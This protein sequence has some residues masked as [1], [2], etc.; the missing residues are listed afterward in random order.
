MKINRLKLTSFGQQKNRII[1]ISDNLNMIFGTT[2][3]A[4]ETVRDFIEAMF[5]G[6]DPDKRE[7]YTPDGKNC[8]GEMLL[9]TDDGRNIRLI[10]N[11]T[12]GHTEVL[13]E[14]GD[15]ITWQY[16]DR[17]GRFM[18]FGQDDTTL[19]QPPSS[20]KT[21]I[22]DLE[23]ELNKLTNSSALAA[24]YSR[25]DSLQQ[26]LDTDNHNG[27]LINQNNEQISQL[28]D[29][30]NDVRDQVQA[31]ADA[32]RYE[33][34]TLKTNNEQIDEELNKL[35]ES[36]DLHK[37]EE[38]SS[39]SKLLERN[40]RGAAERITAITKQLNDLY[41][42]QDVYSERLEMLTS[43]FHL[44]RDE[45]IS[46]NEK[47][48]YAENQEK[49]NGTEP[50]AVAEKLAGVQSW[51]YWVLIVLGIVLDAA[52]LIN[53][54]SYLPK[55]AVF[56]LAF[57]GSFV[58]LGSIAMLIAVHNGRLKMPMEPDFEPITAV[59]AVL[60]KYRKDSAEAF[61]DFY[62]KAMKVFGQIDDL[63]ADLQDIATEIDEARKELDRY[64]TDRNTYREDLNEEIGN[65]DSSDKYLQQR[66]Q[67]E[68]LEEMRDA[69]EKRIQNIEESEDSTNPVVFTS[70]DGRELRADASSAMLEQRIRKLHH[71]NKELRLNANMD[72]REKN[73][74]TYNDVC[75]RILNAEHRID[76]LKTQLEQR[77]E[78]Q[79]KVD[80]TE[81]VLLQNLGMGMQKLLAAGKKVPYI[82]DDPF[83]NLKA[84][85]KAT[86]ITLFRELTSDSQTLLFTG[87]NQIKKIYDAMEWPYSGIPV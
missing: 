41:E 54:G 83:V 76:S 62:E 7:H 45:L 38:A 21:E 79:I 75:R 29:K 27:D 69:N 55:A 5:F 34:D 14:L 32:A 58:I 42:E 20:V 70:G 81:D 12:T 50:S 59:E 28:T 40:E 9:E 24:L 65:T 82:L 63:E 48:H 17:N 8:E 85:E 80:I 30:L 26:V 56:I 35:Y 46:D 11:F 37:D 4:E 61:D 6:M 78:E 3:H 73:V 13:N 77:R 19:Y 84:D 22:S 39:R 10:R 23:N 74:E 31:A 67:I 33:V 86:M 64:T 53:Y 66:E 47:L 25:R 71:A 49:G 60:Q 68:K 43:R 52:A 44:N 87:T 72:N 15:D 51:V 18:L 1:E 57:I 36:T 2:P 16:R